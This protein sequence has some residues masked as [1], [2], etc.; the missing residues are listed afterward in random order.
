VSTAAGMSMVGCVPSLDAVALNGAHARLSA[1]PQY[2]LTD[3]VY[4]ESAELTVLTL[5]V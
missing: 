4:F 2:T 5:I 1:R 3:S